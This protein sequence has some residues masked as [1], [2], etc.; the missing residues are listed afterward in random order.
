MRNL[1]PLQ[2]VKSRGYGGTVVVIGGDIEREVMFLARSCKFDLVIAADAMKGKTHFLQD[3]V[4][5][6]RCE[7]APIKSLATFV[8]SSR[9]L[10]LNVGKG[11]RNGKWFVTEVP[12]GPDST[13]LPT[14]TLDEA[15][16]SSG[17][18]T[19]VKIDA[20]AHELEILQSG[21]E[22]LQKHRPDLCIEIYPGDI[23]LISKGLESY[24]YVQAHAFNPTGMY[25]VHIGR[26]AL[27]IFRFLNNT[28]FWIKS[29]LVWRWKRIALEMAMVS[30]RAAR[31]FRPNTESK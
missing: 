30:R 4:Q 18:I 12:V 15:C 27:T 31:T 17:H 6:G 29:R 5:H 8:S 26:I 7:T 1:D 21:Q 16:R 9:E 3:E 23:Q 24:G 11:A 14:V 19:V 22:T 10:F 20:D 28:P 13:P 25:F 2:Y